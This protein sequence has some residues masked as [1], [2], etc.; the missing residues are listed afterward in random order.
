MD[1]FLE[2]IYKIYVLLNSLVFIS[3]TNKIKN[4]K[5]IYGH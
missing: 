3:V 2:K 5:K 4:G 1:M